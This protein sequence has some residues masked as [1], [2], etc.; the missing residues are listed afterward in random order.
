LE[1]GAKSVAPAYEIEAPEGVDVMRTKYCIKYELG[2][3]RKHPDSGKNAIAFREP[4][5]LANR[6]YKLRLVFDC[7]NCEMIVNL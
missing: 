1:C 6:N 5:Y 3:C 7:K 4:L 2:L